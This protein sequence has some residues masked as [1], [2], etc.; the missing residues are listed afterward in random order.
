[1]AKKY[2]G[3]TKLVCDAFD[4]FCV[5]I[6]DS[7]FAHSMAFHTTLLLLMS[8]VVFDEPKHKPIK[9]SLAF[10]SSEAESE[11]F[12][13]VLLPTIAEPIPI[14]N[15]ELADF[16]KIQIDNRVDLV[17]DTNIDNINDIVENQSSEKYTDFNTKDLIQKLA[18]A[19]DTENEN[20]FSSEEKQETDLNNI[21]KGLSGSIANRKRINDLSSNGRGGV[22]ANDEFGRRLS[23]AG[24]KTGDIQISIMWST[25]DDIDLHITYT[26]GNGLIDNI[27]WTNRVG[28][29]SAGMLDIDRNANSGMLTN[30]PVENIFWQKGSSPKGFFVVYIHFYRSWSGNNKVPVIARFKIGDKFEEI[31]CIAVLY[32]SPQEI[33]RFKYPN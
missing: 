4:W 18:T 1:M 9:I 31:R 14:T 3:K 30:S 13:N 27:N 12:T 5:Y 19:S 32:Q 20:E 15:K 6:H 25:I 8:L 16:E 28:R 22:N 26:P 24:A 11:I 17:S 2:L 29:L 23:D 21:I 7:G 33:A 10:N